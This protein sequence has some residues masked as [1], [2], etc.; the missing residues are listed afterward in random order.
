[1]TSHISSALASGL[2]PS[3]RTATS[4]EGSNPRRTWVYVEG[5]CRP[6]TWRFELSGSAARGGL[7]RS[8]EVSWPGTKL[9]APGAPGAA[10]QG[11]ERAERVEALVAVRPCHA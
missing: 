3:A 1:M 9:V 7:S 11:A 5:C 4:E 6:R 10:A 2:R 8:G